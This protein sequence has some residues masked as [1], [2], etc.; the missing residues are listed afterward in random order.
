MDS[1][2]PID[3]LLLDIVDN[4]WR[5]EVLPFDQ[6]LVPIEKLPDPEA[7]GGDSHLTL[8]EQEQKWTDLALGSLAP[9]AALIDQLNITTI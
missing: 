7:D 2:A 3:D 5:T 8:S 6:I 1:Q 4:V 9:D